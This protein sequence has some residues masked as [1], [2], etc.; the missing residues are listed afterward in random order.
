MGALADESY[1]LIGTCCSPPIRVMANNDCPGG[2]ADFTIHLSL[3][4]EWPGWG[5]PEGPGQPSSP[6]PNSPGPAASQ[7]L[8]HPDASLL[9]PST[10]DICRAANSAPNT[11][12]PVKKK[13]FQ[14]SPPGV[15][16]TSRSPVT[17]DLV[18]DVRWGSKKRRLHPSQSAR[19]DTPDAADMKLGDGLGDALPVGPYDRPPPCHPS[20]PGS[21]QTGKPTA[22]SRLS[23]Q[24]TPAQPHV[25]GSSHNAG[26]SAAQS[27]PAGGIGCTLQE[28]SAGDDL[29]H[30]EPASV[31]MSRH[32]SSQPM[33]TDTARGNAGQP[34]V[35]SETVAAQQASPGRVTGKR[36]LQAH[37][38]ADRECVRTQNRQQERDGAAGPEQQPPQE[39][40]HLGRDS[41]DQGVRHFT[42]TSHML[43][44]ILFQ[45]YD[46]GRP[47][48]KLGQL[49][50]YSIVRIQGL[51]A[52]K[53]N[54]RCQGQVWLSYST[55]LNSQLSF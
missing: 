19:K 1:K 33:A 46:H 13:T 43:T 26:H 15:P 5:I 28:V 50:W 6:L 55:S 22:P 30:H 11:G 17:E 8:H 48:Q 23:C 24:R 31:P 10:S 39:K 34:L 3:D 29:E 18:P 38:T 51:A 53:E 49:C 37:G 36:Q 35:D 14:R 41:A 2:A 40:R 47:N 12:Q 9:S 44:H 20:S 54:Q 25:A 32:P 45:C 42:A 16:Q 27:P 21:H 4:P 52:L 7:P